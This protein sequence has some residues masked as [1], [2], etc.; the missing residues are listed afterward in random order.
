MNGVLVVASK[1]ECRSQWAITRHSLSSFLHFGAEVFHCTVFLLLLP[2]SELGIDQQKCNGMLIATTLSLQR[3]GLISVVTA[4]LEKH[5]L[6]SVQN[7]ACKSKW[8]PKHLL[9]KY[10]SVCIY[11]PFCLYFHEDENTSQ[12]LIQ[13]FPPLT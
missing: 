10:I 2:S 5:S 6:P 3:C 13:P 9:K 1:E 7:R 11:L 12:V 4:P 8:P